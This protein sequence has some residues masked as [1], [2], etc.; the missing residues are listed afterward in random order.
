MTT[1]VTANTT[2]NVILSQLLGVPIDSVLSNTTCRSQFLISD[3]RVL[4]HQS[5]DF[6]RSSFRSFS[7]SLRSCLRS[8]RINYFICS[9]HWFGKKYGSNRLLNPTI[10]FRIPSTASILIPATGLFVNQFLLLLLSLHLE[11]FI[12]HSYPTWHS[13]ITWWCSDFSKKSTQISTRHLSITA[14]LTRSSEVTLSIQVERSPVTWYIV[15]CS[16]WGCYGGVTRRN[17]CD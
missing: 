9:S 3:L 2:N 11:K 14:G 8:N 4:S 1:K 15:G 7:S 13:G 16:D 12:A 5:N 6:L 17:G 10:C